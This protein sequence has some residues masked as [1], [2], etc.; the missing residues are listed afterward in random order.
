MICLDIWSTELILQ[1]DKSESFL[2]KTAHTHP[3]PLSPI[4]MNDEEVEALRG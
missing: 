2:L 1:T 3:H 4:S